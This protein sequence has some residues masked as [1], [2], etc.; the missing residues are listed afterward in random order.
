MTIW[1]MIANAAAVGVHVAAG[2]DEVA[3]VLLMLL[4][5]ML[6]MLLLMLLL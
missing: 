3:A 4:M 2:I 6:L 5:M 1:L